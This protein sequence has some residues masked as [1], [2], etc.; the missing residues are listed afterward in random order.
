MFLYSLRDPRDK[1]YRWVGT[2]TDLRRRLQNHLYLK[3]QKNADPEK[4]HWIQELRALGLRP[5]MLVHA[6]YDCR[7][8]AVL[9]ERWFSEALL[10]AGE[11]LFGKMHGRSWTKASRIKMSLQRRSKK[12]ASQKV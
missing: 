4:Y 9:A 5:E 7:E 8:E 2:T 10:T 1:S 12:W 6:A 3:P 11:P